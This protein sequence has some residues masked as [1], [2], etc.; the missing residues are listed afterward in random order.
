LSEHTL[1]GI[2]SMPKDI[3][4][5]RDGTGPKRYLYIINFFKRRY[6]NFSIIQGY[7]GFPSHP[8]LSPEGERA[9]CLNLLRSYKI[10]IVRQ[11]SRIWI[12][13]I[14]IPS[15]HT[16]R[17]LDSSLPFQCQ[18]PQIFRVNPNL[19]TIFGEWFRPIIVLGPEV[20]SRRSLAAGTIRFSMVRGVRQG[21]VTEWSTRRAWPWQ[22]SRPCY[23][24]LFRTS[25]AFSDI[26]FLMVSYLDIPA[27]QAI[28][29]HIK[30]CYPLKR[31]YIQGNG[32]LRNPD[33][34][35]F[36]WHWCGFLPIVIRRY[37]MPHLA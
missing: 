2:R 10:S 27:F 33:I 36:S 24:Y 8:A 20:K 11:M 1:W 13:N 6:R 17:E 14:G 26:I 19:S 18:A 28:L 37:A 16:T 29:N 12:W 35:N 7:F 34:A 15:K 3:P 21:C 23:Q 9:G 22:I 25:N 4:K 30:C 32:R 31:W 5:R